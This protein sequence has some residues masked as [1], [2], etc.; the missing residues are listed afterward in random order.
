M[1]VSASAHALANLAPWLRAQ[2]LAISDPQ[3]Q[4]LE[5]YLENLL[6][7]NRRIALVS[8]NDPTSIVEKHFADALVAARYCAGASSL[9]DLGSGAGFPGIVAAILRP[10]T[11]V[12]LIEARRKKAS[13]LTDTVRAASLANVDVVCDRIE[14]VARQPGRSGRYEI[15]IARALGSVAELLEYSR[16]LLSD[17]GRAIAMKGPSYRNDLEAVPVESLGFHPP[18]IYS[19]SLPDLSQRVLLSF[20]RL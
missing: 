15:A 13:F 12:T 6:L 9:V 8:Q 19:Y 1:P 7:W 16:A 4:Q 10:E 11:C 2:Q 20:A 5:T 14:A 18:T 17:S 3:R